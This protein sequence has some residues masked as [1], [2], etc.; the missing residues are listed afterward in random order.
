MRLIP[1]LLFASSALLAQGACR[2]GEDF[3]LHRR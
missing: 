2:A 3:L 1:V